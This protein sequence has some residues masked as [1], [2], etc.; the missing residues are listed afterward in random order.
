MSATTQPG[1]LVADFF[2]GSGTTLV[3]AEKLGR[4]RIGC[5]AG[6]AAIHASKKRLVELPGASFEILAVDGDPPVATD[7]PRVE[8]SARGGPA[9]A[10]EI[11]LEGEGADAVDY[12]AVDWDH[13]GHVFRHGWRAGRRHARE[14]VP[15]SAAHTYPSAGSR[16]IA[17]RIAGAGGQERREVIR[18][19]AGDD[20]GRRETP[21]P[22]RSRR[23]EPR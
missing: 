21:G 18:W 10:V 2:A 6:H 4:R 14:R 22:G 17:V 13:D 5:D 16:R 7:G 9:R 1:D 12:W 11:R 3:A 19:R 23:Q 8:V 20:E 15:L